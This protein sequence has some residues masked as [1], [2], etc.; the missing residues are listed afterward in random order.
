MLQTLPFYF[1][2]N[3][4]TWQLISILHEYYYY[5]VIRS[6]DTITTTTTTTITAITL[7][8]HDHPSCPS[9]T[10]TCVGVASNTYNY[11]HDVYNQYTN[12]FVM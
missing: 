11:I 8:G 5:P 10:S 1:H 12:T 7:S 9:D 2:N 3:S 6:Q 4:Y